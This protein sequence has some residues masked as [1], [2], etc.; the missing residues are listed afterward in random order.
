[1]ISLRFHFKRLVSHRICLLLLFLLS[2][3]QLFADKSINGTWDGVVLT[4]NQNNP[5]FYYLETEGRFYFNEPRLNSSLVRL[6]IGH[7]YDQSV[8]LWLGYDYLQSLS[9]SKQFTQITWQ[10]VFFQLVNTDAVSI[11]YY[12][13]LGEFFYSRGK[14]TAYLSRNHTMIL[15]NNFFKYNIS[16]MFFNELFVNL[17]HPEWVSKKTISQNRIFAGVR[18]PLFEHTD[19]ILGYLNRTVYGSRETLNEHL[20]RLQFIVTLD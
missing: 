15:F 19:V 2:S 7:S 3:N 20:L 8:K 17:N 6:A 9:S 10:Q 5:Y 12:S 14:G 1:M 13:R 4:T 18:K 11:T 16:P